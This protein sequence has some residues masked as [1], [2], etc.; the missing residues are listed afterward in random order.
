M[1]VSY[2][3]ITWAMYR[4][5]L[6]SLNGM[7]PLSQFLSYSVGSESRKNPRALPAFYDWHLAYSGMLTNTQAS[8]TKHMT[9]SGGI[10]VW[11]HGL[12]CAVWAALFGMASASLAGPIASRTS[13]WRLPFGKANA[14]PPYTFTQCTS[15]WPKQT[16]FEGS[17]VLAAQKLGA[18]AELRSRVA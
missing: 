8:P 4:R 1:Q 6:K 5:A 16:L 13:K 17:W 10:G 12:Q 15:N 18:Q 9:Q 3:C 11:C 7:V 2:A 14:L